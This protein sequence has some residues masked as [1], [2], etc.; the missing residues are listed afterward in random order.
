MDQRRRYCI[1]VR[2]AHRNS[3]SAAA[4]SKITIMDIVERMRADWDRRARE[5]AYFYAGFA[6]RNQSDDDFFSS[7]PDTVLTIEAESRAPAAGRRSYR[8][9]RSKSAAGPD[10]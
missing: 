2:C 1:S 9:A 6:R 3:D 10:D 5:D 8:A 4:A 7:A